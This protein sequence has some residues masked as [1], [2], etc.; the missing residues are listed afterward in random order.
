MLNVYI[1][2]LDGKNNN[3]KVW[4]FLI[5][6]IQ[7]LLIIFLFSRFWEIRQDRNYIFDLWIVNLRKKCTREKKLNIFV[8]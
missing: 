3:E 6:D 4:G 2:V 8:L 5:F 1:N 7:S